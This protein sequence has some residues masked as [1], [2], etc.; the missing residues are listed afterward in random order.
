M[1]NGGVAFDFGIGYAWDENNMIV[2]LIDEVSYY[3][4]FDGYKDLYMSQ[5]FS[6]ACYYH[7]FGMTGKSPFIKAGLGLQEGMFGQAQVQ[8]AAA[9]ERVRIYPTLSD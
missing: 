7:Y 4:D 9:W 2:F 5:S 6:G 1:K 8:F 3:D